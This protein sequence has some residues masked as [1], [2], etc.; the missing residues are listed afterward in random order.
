MEEEKAIRLAETLRL[1]AP[2]GKVGGLGFYSAI[3]SHK[4]K[5]AADSMPPEVR[6]LYSHFVRAGDGPSGLSKFDIDG[7]LVKLD[8]LTQPTIGAAAGKEKK[9]KK[10]APEPEADDEAV[11]AAAKRAKRAKKAKKLAAAAAAAA[12]EEPAAEEPAGGKKKKRKALSIDEA[13]AAAAAEAKAKAKRTTVP[14]SPSFSKMS[15]QRA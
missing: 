3:G 1:L 2:K 12:E 14:K 6:T 5:T 7:K 13:F 4:R 15:W 10:K 9:K 8:D 11:A